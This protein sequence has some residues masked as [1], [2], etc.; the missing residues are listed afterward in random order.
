VLLGD[1]ADRKLRY[2]YKGRMINTA[3]K[4]QAK[5]KS[6]LNFRKIVTGGFGL[7]L[8]TGFRTF[9]II[10]VPIFYEFPAL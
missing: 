4:T 7:K 9:P 8:T 1:K 2:S 10:H 6:G 3:L 5:K